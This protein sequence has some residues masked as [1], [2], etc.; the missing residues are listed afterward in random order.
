MGMGRTQHQRMQRR[1][2]D[3]VIRVAA[4]AAD[5]GIVFLAKDALA[6]TEFDWSH[7]SSRLESGTVL[8]S[9]MQWNSGKRK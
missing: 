5:Q 7:E 8:S 3:I 9:I 1:C 4:L 6:D 2:G